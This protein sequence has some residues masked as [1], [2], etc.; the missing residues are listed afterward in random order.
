[1]DK[2]PI[3]VI[4]PVRNEE[5]NLPQMLPLL[6][7]FDE[8]IV[9]DS[10]ST[11]NTQEIVKS[12]GYQLVEFDWNGH[13]PKKRNWTLRNVPIRNEWVF[14]VDADEYMTPQFMDGLRH[15][16]KD[17]KDNVG[18]WI[19]YTNYFMGNLLKHGDPIHKLALFKKTAGE[20]ERIDAEDDDMRWGYAGLEL[21][22]QPILCGPIG[23]ICGKIDH[24]ENRGLEAYIRKHNEFST[25]EAMRYLKNTKEKDGLTIRQKVKYT[26]MDSWWLYRLYF[27]YI[28]FI[29]FGFLDGKAG[30]IYAQLK[31]QYFFSIKAKI[32]E[33]R[34]A[35]E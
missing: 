14:F 4:V 34:R 11:D 3:T 9:V 30:Y 6:K 26:L 18:Y 15:E 19:Y 22:E 28:Y 1:M 33:L 8:V 27:I 21:H 35:K 10:H 24:R 23:T 5:K 16:F 17:T 12:F 32:D 7:D 2:L 29:K 25:W 31:K 20:Y 13:F